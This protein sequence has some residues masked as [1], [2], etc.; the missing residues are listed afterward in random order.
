MNAQTYGSYIN[1]QWVK[2]GNEVISVTDPATGELIGNVVSSGTTEIKQAVEAAYKAFPD[3]AERP[4]I[5]RSKILK[6]YCQLLL[7]RKEELAKLI[8]RE[9]G[10]PYKETLGEVDYAISFLDWYAEEA[11]RVYG[12][13]IPGKSQNHRIQVLK[14]PVGVAASITP[15]N[16]PASMIT[17]KLGPALAAG[18]TFINKPAELTPLTALK[19]AEWA[20]EAG[21]P[22]GVF[23]VVCTQD[24]NDFTNV[25]MDD[26]RVRKISFTGSTEVGRLIM[27][28]SAEQIK[29]VSLELG[30]HAPFIVCED[31]DLE[32]VVEAAI[33][34]KFRN[35]GQTCVCANR[36]YVHEGIYD[37]FLEQFAKRITKLKMGNGLDPS[38]D[39]GP[40]INQASYEKV[41]KHVKDALAKG[42]TCLVGGNGQ[43]D[44]SKGV[45]FYEP[46]LLADTNPDMLVMYEE[47]FG[48]VAAVQKFSTD[49]EAI[50]MANDTP[51]GLASYLFTPNVSRGMRIAEKLEY[52]IVG[53]NDGVPSTAQAPFGGV[54]QSGLGREGAIEG[55]EEYLTTKYIS[56]M[57]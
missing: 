40:L 7:E 11:R 21:I 19:L 16:F 24:P 52:G 10:R 13:L 9:M 51:Y 45:F 56:L 39:I 36:F 31:A 50:R 4:A 12:R 53:W 2:N 3:W 37:A 29:R 46:T 33:L 8:T 27:R 22:A 43:A 15:W 17:R 48:P 41:E 42:A 28:R 1:G 18:C 5:E 25:I 35:T 54:K 20:T 47:T 49:E 26:M 55:I 32:Q 30:G 23:N 14:Q 6:G 34:C 44:E 57:L 38:S